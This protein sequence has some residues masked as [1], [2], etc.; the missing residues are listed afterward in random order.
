MYALAK[1]QEY[2]S[3]QV[4]IPVGTYT[5]IVTIPHLYFIRDKADLQR[6]L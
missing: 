6:W 5:H 1:L 2:V 4:G 3:Q